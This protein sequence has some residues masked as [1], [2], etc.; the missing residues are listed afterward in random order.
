MPLSKKHRDSVKKTGVQPEGR[1]SDNDKEKSGG[2]VETKKSSQ[3]TK[4]K[5]GGEG[6][7]RGLPAKVK[8]AS[9][10]KGKARGESPGAPDV[11]YGE[12]S[13]CLSPLDLSALPVKTLLENLLRFLQLIETPGGG[14]CMYIAFCRALDVGYVAMTRIEY[15]RNW[16]FSGEVSVTALRRVVAAM[17]TQDKYDSYRESAPALDNMQG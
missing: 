1:G 5:G 15:L 7:T 11:P 6:E 8:V 2:G 10:G 13:L 3:G 16:G 9:K 14:H 4:R 17:A 12:G